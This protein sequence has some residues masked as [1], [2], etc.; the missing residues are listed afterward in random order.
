MPHAR[1]EVDICGDLLLFAAHL[2]KYWA[3]MI[4]STVG[5]LEAHPRGPERTT[6]GYLVSVTK[7][8]TKVKMANAPNLDEFI[9]GAGGSIEDG[10]PLGSGTGN[11]T[12]QGDMR[13]QHFNDRQNRH[14]SELQEMDDLVIHP[15]FVKSAMF[16][17]WMRFQT[18]VKQRLALMTPHLTSVPRRACGD[19]E[20]HFSA[21]ANRIAIDLNHPQCA[22]PEDL[23]PPN[24]SFLRA[25]VD[26]DYE[27]HK[28]N[29]LC[30]QLVVTVFNYSLGR[31]HIEVHPASALMKKYP[32]VNW[33]EHLPCALR[34]GGRMELYLVL[35][36][37]GESTAQ[38]R[39]FA[40]RSNLSI[41]EDGVQ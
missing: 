20:V 30:R 26:H 28:H 12:H 41:L 18:M 14:Y 17:A 23:T 21:S 10:C 5:G 6:P 11:I 13:V 7:F 37:T 9:E 39:I 19:M 35:V 15:S 29:I 16:D 22:H 4:S 36:A 24:V 25:L 33:H 1:T 40:L 38:A 3:Q 31:A 32:S 27:I 2:T 8:L 34:S